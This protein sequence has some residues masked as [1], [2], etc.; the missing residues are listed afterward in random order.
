LILDFGF[1]IEEE[2]AMEWP[3][4][5]NALA[6]NLK[7]K[8]Q[9]PKLPRRSPALIAALLTLILQ[10]PAMAHPQSKPMR[11]IKVGYPL[12]GSSVIFGSRTAPVRLKNTD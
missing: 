10:W 5:S 8:I 7:S 6:G 4:L 12:G 1:S 11:E 3:N 2:N 9:N